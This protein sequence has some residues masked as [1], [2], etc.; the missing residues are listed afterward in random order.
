MPGTHAACRLAC[1]SAVSSSERSTHAIRTIGGRTG[2]VSEPLSSSTSG[3]ANG[4][5]SRV[6]SIRRAHA[7]ARPAAR[8]DPPPAPGRLRGSRGS[9]R[10]RL[11]GSP[12]S[13]MNRAGS[14]ATSTKPLAT[15]SSPCSGETRCARSCRTSCRPSPRRAVPRAARGR[16]PC[17]RRTT[18][19][20]APKRPRCRSS[21]GRARRRPALGNGGVAALLGQQHLVAGDGGRGDVVDDGRAR[22]RSGSRTTAGSSRTARSRRRTAAR[23]SGR[24][25]RT[26]RCNRPRRPAR[27]TAPSAPRWVVSR[28]A[29]AATPCSPGPL[30]PRVRP[31]RARRSGRS[32]GRRRACTV[33]PSSRIVVTVVA[34]LMSPDGQPRG[35]HRHQVGAVRIDAAQVGLDQQLGDDAGL[36][37]GHAVTAQDAGERGAQVVGGDEGGAARAG[38]AGALIRRARPRRS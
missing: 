22:R 20:D 27:C 15:R 31:P 25:A 36:A 35:V 38:S 11:R 33:E 7:R 23:M 6:R 16:T 32:P 10:R 18:A 8:G 24:S 1:R 26:G 12:S 2:V 5:P 4:M 17:G 19:D 30:A 29:T 34:G 14:T 9:A 37:G 13:G 3:A 28:T 21:G